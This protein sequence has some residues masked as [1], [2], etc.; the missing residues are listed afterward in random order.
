M[1][2]R[3]SPEAIHLAQDEVLTG[4]A[5]ALD[6]QPTGVL[7]RAVG[8][9]IDILLATVLM[10]AA[11][12]IITGPLA[13]LLP[14]GAQQMTVIVTLVLVLVVLP[15]AVE[16]TT[17]GRSLGRLAVGT[18]IVRSDGGAS[19]FRQALIR[20]LVGVLEIY[21]TLGVV[22]VLAGAFT[23]RSQRLGDLLAGT[24]SQRTR[25]APLPPSLPPVPPMLDQW[26]SVVD[27]ARLPDRL[28]RRLAQFLGQA[29]R[30][31]PAA[32]DRIAEELRD[33]VSAFVYPMP[34]TDPLTALFGIAAARRDRELRA[35]SAQDERRVDLAPILERV[36]PGFPRH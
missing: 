31:A 32:R 4:E 20:A 29:P 15:T 14:E 28:S 3:P 36:P 34:N 30:L 11:L 13:P 18:R 17:R 21:F 27:V 7:L 5:V 16:A 9:V 2:P 19:G 24:Y 12:L 1:T 33:E 26:A 25:V 10:I 23:P 6:V 35:L 8:A 22:A